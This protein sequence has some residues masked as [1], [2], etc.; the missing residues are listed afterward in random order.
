MSAHRCSFSLCCW[1]TH[2]TLR[3][4]L[5]YCLPMWIKSVRKAHFPAPLWL[6]R[7]RT[8]KMEPR[9]TGPWRSSG[10]CHNISHDYEYDYTVAY[11]MSIDEMSFIIFCLLLFLRNKRN[12]S[13]GLL[14]FSGSSIRTEMHQ[15]GTIR[16]EQ[17]DYNIT[18]CC[19]SY[20]IL[21]YSIFKKNCF[22]KLLPCVFVNGK[23]IFHAATFFV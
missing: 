4:L 22:F 10:M 3:F 14:W 9:I 7:C 19:I 16:L 12:I 20:I 13:T 18:I 6:W 23:S 17:E 2:C 15:G 5:T 1:P 11:F 8:R 21:I